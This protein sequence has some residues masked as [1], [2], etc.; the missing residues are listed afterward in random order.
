MF[1]RHVWDAASVTYEMG[2]IGY[3]LP[4]FVAT[5][6]NG[7]DGA[8]YPY[9]TCYGETSGDPNISFGEDNMANKH[10]RRNAAQSNGEEVEELRDIEDLEQRVL[11]AATRRIESNNKCFLFLILP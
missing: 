6:S 10:G 3:S 9:S 11:E 4:V 8:H 2:V 5:D 1:L 7:N